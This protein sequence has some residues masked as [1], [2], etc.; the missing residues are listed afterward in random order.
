VTQSDSLVLGSVNGTNNA[1]ADT[2]VGIGTTAPAGPLH[3]KSAGNEVLFAGSNGKIGIGTSA[4]DRPLQI[5]STPSANAEL[6]IGGSGDETKDVFSGMGVNL[7]TGPSFN[8]GYSGYSFGRSSGFFNVRPDASAVYPNPSLRFMTANL[9]RMVITADG[10]IGIGTT[11]PLEML[12]V[13]GNVRIGGQ[14]LYGAADVELPDYVFEP[15]YRLMPVADLE[16][17][18]ARE[19][20][21]PNVPSASEIKEKG[22]SLS[23]FQMKLLEK[24]EELTLYTV[25]QAKTI[26]EQQQAGETKDARIS[27]LEARL[28]ALEQVM[29]QP[30][31]QPHK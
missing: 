18:L 22:L 7:S 29:A 20:H 2:K 9:Q 1:T 8:F 6:H 25:Q 27:G 15:E 28:A 26:R 14:I 31:A 21:L 10:R 30:Q 24:I 5:V 11:N 19:K 17:F 13:T 4:P 3:I 12:H 16:K 23:D